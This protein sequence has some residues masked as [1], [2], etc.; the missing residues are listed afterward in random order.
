MGEL[1]VG[2]THFILYAFSLLFL[3][4]CAGGGNEI[5]QSKR[6]NVLDVK[7]RLSALNLDDKFMM[8][9][10]TR[11]YVVNDYLVFKDYSSTDKM[12]HLFDKNT[13]KY[14]GSTGDLGQGP[15]E[16]ISL[17]DVMISRDR[18][19]L[20]ADL[21]HFCIYSYDIDSLRNDTDYLPV[22]R[23]RINK[24]LVPTYITYLSDTLCY[25]TFVVAKDDKTYSRTIG[26]WNM[27]S[28]EVILMEY[29][30]PDVKDKQSNYVYSQ[31]HDILVEYQGRADL[32]SIFD[33]E[34]NLLHNVYGPDWNDG[35]SKL[36]CFFPAV[37]CKDYIIAAYE[38]SPYQDYKLP[39]K[40]HVF[41]LNGEY[42]KTLE[43]GKR[44]H[45]LSADEGNE[46]LFLSFDDEM[47]FGY[48]D[49]KD[50]L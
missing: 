2:K 21:G 19:L 14:I 7:D 24:E 17:G 12:I 15:G 23:Y 30:H 33:G 27:R 41:R 11:A 6:D 39:T 16:I 43:T 1:K 42:V 3:L 9:Q 40:L 26:K 32:I 35:D 5:H 46:R 37:I 48:L 44:I 4:S 49:L 22:I 47:Q 28:D 31:E 20:V 10:A 34:F 8:G 36:L 45:F 29:E 50:L 38:G 13:F 18:K 25:A